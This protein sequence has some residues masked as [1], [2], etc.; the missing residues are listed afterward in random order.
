MCAMD[1][2]PMKLVT[3]ICEALAREPLTELI[4][5]CGAHGY[6]LFAVEGSGAKGLRVADIQEFGNIQVE[7]ILRPAHSEKL[8]E[9]LQ[10]DFF[11]RYT[12]IAYESDV[13]VLRG[14]KF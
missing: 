13:R 8:L 11:P 5:E 1:T 14:E 4:E 10:Q 3:I 6:T 9:R 2:F 7:V 12:M